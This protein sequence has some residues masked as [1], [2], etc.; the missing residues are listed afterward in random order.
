[1]HLKITFENSDNNLKFLE[2]DSIIICEVNAY[3]E[4]LG[5]E[6]WDLKPPLS[7]IAFLKDV[8]KIESLA[9][10]KNKDSNHVGVCAELD[11]VDEGICGCEF[12]VSEVKE[13]NDFP[14][15]WK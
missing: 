2:E 5:E 15:I 9:L 3:I 11:L 6:T 8:R 7:P 10:Y 14:K 4:A 12:T 1:M 13:V